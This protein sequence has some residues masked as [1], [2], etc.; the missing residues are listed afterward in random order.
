MS[1][2]RAVEAYTISGRLV[3]PRASL[4]AVMVA[5]VPELVRR[6]I[7]AAGMRSQIT[8]ASSSSAAVGV[9]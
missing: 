5:S 7:S 6:T 3:Y 1:V 2:I 4:T 8:C 9:P